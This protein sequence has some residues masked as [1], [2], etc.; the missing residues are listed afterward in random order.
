M[1][2]DCSSPSASENSQLDGAQIERRPHLP[3]HKR[4]G[5]PNTARPDWT[6]HSRISSFRWNSR[7]GENEEFKFLNFLA[8]GKTRERW[9]VGFILSR[10]SVSA[11]PAP[12]VRGRPGRRKR[13][14]PNG[15]KWTS[16]LLL[17]K[18]SARQ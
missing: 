11:S 13:K 9:V 16:D 5:T 18:G 3:T 17:E 14:A 1:N 7:R 2:S 12:G 8:E 6:P 15:D 4:H 10:V